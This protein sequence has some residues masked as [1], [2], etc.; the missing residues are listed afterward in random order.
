MY[1]CEQVVSHVQYSGSCMCETCTAFTLTRFGSDIGSG[2]VTK[3]SVNRAKPCRIE[4]CW[5]Y[6]TEPGQHG[7]VRFYRECERFRNCAS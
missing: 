6:Q 1:M 5:D 3:C 7:A 2:T 4:P